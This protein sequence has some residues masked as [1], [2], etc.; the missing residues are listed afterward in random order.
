MKNFFNKNLALVAM[1]VIVV[2]NLFCACAGETDLREPETIVKTNTKEVPVLVMQDKLVNIV[3]NIY[4]DGKT[5]VVGDK[6]AATV[7]VNHEF[8]VIEMPADEQTA[9]VIT[10]SNDLDWY[11]SN[12]QHTTGT[13]NIVAGDNYEIFG[14]LYPANQYSTITRVHP[15]VSVVN[16]HHVFEGSAN[17]TVAEETK[18]KSFNFDI[19]RQYI[20]SDPSVDTE[21]INTVDTLIQVV[22]KTD[23]IVNTVEVI[24]RDT[25]INNITTV[26]HD[27][28]TVTNTVTVTDTVKVEV[29]R[30][31][32]GA[33][34]VKSVVNDFGFSKGSM[35][36]GNKQ[37]LAVEIRHQYPMLDVAKNVLG[38]AN[39]SNVSALKWEG[40][41]GQKTNASVNAQGCTVNGVDYLRSEYKSLVENSLVQVRTIYRVYGVYTNE[42]GDVCDFEMEMA[43]SYL[44][45]Y[46]EVVPQ[47]T[48][49]VIRYE[50]K[51]TY[52]DKQSGDVKLRKLTLKVTKFVN[53]VE[54]EKWSYVGNVIISG[55]V[56]GYDMYVADA[57]VLRKDYTDAEDFD[58][59]YNYTNR[60]VSGN[61]KFSETMSSHIW[62]YKNYFRAHSGGEVNTNSEIRF[63]TMVVTFRDGDFE[64]TSKSFD[65]NV[66]VVYDNIDNDS[67]LNGT[68][69]EES[70]RHF[71]YGGT[72]RLTVK[73]L[74]DGEEFFTS[75]A[76]S[77]LY[78]QD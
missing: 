38:S 12:N 10:S 48:E 39:F 76:V 33:D 61:E 28:I 67:E 7:D 22:V 64:W 11:D 27:T 56:A 62:S 60:P 51:D 45:S 4:F 42:N 32:K 37:L 47:N 6:V 18:S 41:D 29:E 35:T 58:A 72:H 8:P 25:I 44:Q 68:T 52:K 57:K 71:T 1:V 70:G 43:P 21:I 15:K 19:A 17:V 69:R 16:T 74:V 75:T 54:V 13:L 3:S 77:P 34:V 53:D 49:D 78:V 55:Y 46:T 23:T 20:L 40:N 14:T 65:K 5:I 31:V 24:K 30:F 9:A 26:V 59:T 2:A 36:L 50:V 63:Q 66:E 73:N